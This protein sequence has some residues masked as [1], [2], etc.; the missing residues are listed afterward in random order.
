MNGYVGATPST[1]GLRV[2]RIAVPWLSLGALLMTS[3]MIWS[4][5]QTG[6]RTV[7]TSMPGPIVATA[8]VEPTS[9]AVATGTIAVIRVDGIWLRATPDASGEMLSAVKKG[10][11]LEV[12]NRTDTWL[13][14]KDSLGRIGWVANSTKSVEIRKK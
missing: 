10:A 8:S 13:R 11:K 4:D 2:L 9:S 5:F 1:P 12:L 3:M 6:L 7:K 14:V